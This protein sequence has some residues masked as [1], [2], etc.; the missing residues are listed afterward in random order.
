MKKVLAYVVLAMLCSTLVCAQ[1][2][3]VDPFQYYRFGIGMYFLELITDRQAYEPGDTVIVT[4]TVENRMEAPLAEGRVRVQIFYNDATY[5]EQIFDEFFSAEN[6]NLQEN[7]KIQDEAF[8][9]LPAQAPSGTYT[10]K[11]YFQSDDYFNLAGLSFACY[12]PPGTPAKTTEFEVKNIGPKSAIFFDKESTTLNGKAYE[13][14]GMIPIFENTGDYTIK[15]PLVNIGDQKSV[16]VIAAA[17]E[18]DDSTD[19]TFLSEKTMQQTVELGAQGKQI[20]E[21]KLASL[22][23]GVYQVKVQADSKDE[24]AILKIRFAI[25]GDK[26]RIYYQGLSSF[27][28][29][30]NKQVT[31]FT[32]FS[33][34]TDYSSFFDGSVEMHLVDKDKRELFADSTSV[35][36]TSAPAGG[37][38]TFTP[39][40]DIEEATLQVILKDAQ[41]GTLDMREVT[42]DISEFEGIEK[43]LSITETT[44]PAETGSRMGYRVTYMSEEGKPL[45]GNM[46]VYLLD[47]KNLPLFLRQNN[48]EGELSGT[49]DIP[50]DAQAGEYTLRVRELDTKAKAEKK[51]IVQAAAAAK[52]EQAVPKVKNLTFLYISLGA[53]LI[54]GTILVVKYT[55]KKT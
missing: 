6:I 50:S 41:G 5:G 49:I 21:Y 33:G 53:L 8:Y 39:S 1:I 43:L 26:A 31:L 2:M 13:F 17:Y 44:S 4:Y 12:G 18:W 7:A 30:A 40:A 48:I 38:T 46:I 16:N 22:S 19:K 45:K 10:V 9:T 34:S 3:P 52:P 36:Y 28:L 20:I 51:V 55:K 25:S 11:V 14:T 35:K 47:S 23:P 27:P 54:L 24:K 15:I 37:M 42:Y 29:Q 32:T